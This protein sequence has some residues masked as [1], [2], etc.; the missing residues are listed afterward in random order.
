MKTFLVIL[1]VLAVPQVV[2]L[3]ALCNAGPNSGCATLGDGSCQ[4]DKIQP[5]GTASHLGV[6]TTQTTPVIAGA[7]RVPPSGV[8][9]CVCMQ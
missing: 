7:K 9:S 1:L 4:Y 5:C 8:S 3:S 2:S 6:C